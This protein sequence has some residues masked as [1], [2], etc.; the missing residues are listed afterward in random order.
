M[1]K[2]PAKLASPRFAVALPFSRLCYDFATPSVCLRVR[3]SKVPAHN[4]LGSDY[5]LIS[6]S[7]WCSVLSVADAVDGAL[8]LST[9]R[10]RSF[11]RDANEVV[12]FLARNPLNRGLCPSECLSHTPPG[13]LP[14]LASTSLCRHISVALGLC[15]PSFTGL[16]CTAG[17]DVTALRP[18][19]KSPCVSANQ[20]LRVIEVRACGIC[21]LLWTRT[22][23]FQVV[24]AGTF[25]GLPCVP[26]CT[27]M[28]FFSP[29]DHPTEPG[30]GATV[31]PLDRQLCTQDNLVGAW[32]L[33]SFGL[34]GWHFSW[35]SKLISERKELEY[36]SQ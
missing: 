18:I 33:A 34:S 36:A 11:D 28:H 1:K 12:A 21:V 19:R 35:T 20:H 6:V 7:C 9:R 22:P 31:A 13:E 29:G 16:L 3:V 26:C 25:D 8:G 30:C 32:E 2:R 10:Q 23:A 5:P 24:V 27:V 4:R 17:L 15:F 14:G